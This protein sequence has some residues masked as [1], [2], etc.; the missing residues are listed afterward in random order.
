M[1][2]MTPKQ[3]RKY[4]GHWNGNRIV[5]IIKDGR[6]IYCGLINDTDLSQ[7]YWHNGRYADEYQVERD[8]SMRHR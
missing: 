1:T 6:V 7:D 4:L 3:I 8:G 5:R 2:T